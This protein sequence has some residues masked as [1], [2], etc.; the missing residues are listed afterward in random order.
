MAI[1]DIPNLDTAILS[2]DAA[3]WGKFEEYVIPRSFTIRFRFKDG[4]NYWGAEFAIGMSEYGTPT[5]HQVTIDGNWHILSGPRFPSA[6]WRTKNKEIRGVNRWQLKFIEQH[7]FQL[8]EMALAAAIHLHVPNM[9][10]ENP[11]WSN[12]EASL[13]ADE[14]RKITKRI[15]KRIRQKITPEFLETVAAI[16]TDAVLKKENPIEAIAERLKCAHRTAQ[17]YATKARGR[18]L[19]PPTSPGKVTVKKSP[20]REEGK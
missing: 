15:H 8:L 2:F 17:E 9:S 20:K 4:P 7:R 3:K 5:L 1:S 6:D 13:G 12:I 14:L 18:N 10:D 11:E 16:Y 19:L